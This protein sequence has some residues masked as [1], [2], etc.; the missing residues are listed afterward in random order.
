MYW[1][2]LYELLNLFLFK[3]QFEDVDMTISNTIRIWFCSL[4]WCRKEKINDT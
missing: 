3:N 1:F 4:F 2:C